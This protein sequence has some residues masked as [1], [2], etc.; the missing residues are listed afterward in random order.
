M[1]VGKVTNTMHAE[2]GQATLMVGET[3]M[4]GMKPLG[5]LRYYDGYGWPCWVRLGIRWRRRKIRMSAPDTSLKLMKVRLK[6]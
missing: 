3:A 5:S 4:C 2:S 6:G 1:I